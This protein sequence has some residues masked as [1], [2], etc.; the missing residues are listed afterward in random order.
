MVSF[1]PNGTPTLRPFKSV[2]SQSVRSEIFVGRDIPDTDRTNRL[3]LACRWLLLRP[4][5]GCCRSRITH[6]NNSIP[7][8]I[9]L[10]VRTALWQGT[11]T[12]ALPQFPSSLSSLS[13]FLSRTASA[14]STIR[15]QILSTIVCLH[16]LILR[17]LISFFCKC[18]LP[19]CRVQR[20]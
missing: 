7:F 6:H 9:P 1:T 14:S 10:I 19:A 4:V 18:L 13:I 20:N 17:V 3:L 8:F 5:A 16:R 2:E 12:S 11:R 15:R